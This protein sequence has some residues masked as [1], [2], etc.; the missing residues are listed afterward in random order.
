MHG[1]GTYTYADGDQYEGDWKDDRRHGKGTV[2]Y[3]AVEGGAAEKYEGDWSDG[4][5]HGYGKYFYADGGAY[6][7]RAGVAAGETARER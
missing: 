7:G 1:R 4:K 6:E 3:A 5:M 2:T